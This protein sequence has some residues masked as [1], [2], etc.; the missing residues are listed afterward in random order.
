LLSGSNDVR[1]FAAPVSAELYM[2]LRVVPLKKY[3]CEWARRLWYFRIFMNLQLVLFLAL[4]SGLGAFGGAFSLWIPVALA[5][6]TFTST[7]LQ[8]FA[9]NQIV[10]AINLAQTML[11]DFELRW[12]GSD[13][14][15]SGNKSTLVRMTERLCCDVATTFSGAAGVPEELEDDLFD[16]ASE[17]DSRHTSRDGRRSAGHSRGSSRMTSSVVTPF[18]RSGTSTPY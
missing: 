15:S 7:I 11:K 9:P 2:E 10:V 6:A 12:Q 14:A 5:L 1:D 4:G 18:G 16:E 13:M 3:F 17:P 8:W